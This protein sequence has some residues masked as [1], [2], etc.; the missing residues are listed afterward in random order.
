VFLITHRLS[1]IR[2]AH[3]VLYLN[4]GHVAAFGPHD[5]LFQDNNTYRSFIEAEAGMSMEKKP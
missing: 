2:Q 4:D 5:K 3:N 1:T